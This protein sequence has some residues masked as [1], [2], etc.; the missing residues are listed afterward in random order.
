M[1]RTENVA[2]SLTGEQLELSA[3]HR[4]VA[5]EMKEDKK[6]NESVMTALCKQARK[7]CA[8]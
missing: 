3:D 8:K 7:I 6:H 1:K 5:V 2:D 4:C